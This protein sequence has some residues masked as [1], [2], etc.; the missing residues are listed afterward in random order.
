VATLDAGFHADP[1][2]LYNAPQ[3]QG[4][5]GL[6]GSTASIQNGRQLVIDPG[7]GFLGDLTVTVTA[8]DGRST[9]ARSFILSVVES[10]QDDGDSS[11]LMYAFADGKLF[12]ELDAA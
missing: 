10:T 4:G 5:G 3:P 2:R 7:S 8:T 12:D 6:A 9:V 11:A 1:S